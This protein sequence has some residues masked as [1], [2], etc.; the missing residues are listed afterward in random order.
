MKSLFLAVV[1]MTVSM[2]FA[3]ANSGAKSDQTKPAEIKI[4]REWK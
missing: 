1:V 4:V 2:S 3:F